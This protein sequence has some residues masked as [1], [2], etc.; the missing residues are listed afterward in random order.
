MKKGKVVFKRLAGLAILVL[1]FPACTLGDFSTPGIALGTVMMIV[2]LAIFLT[3][4]D[5]GMNA[6]TDTIKRVSDAQN[7]SI[8]ELHRA[9]A[10]MDTPLG[11]GWIGTVQTIAGPCLIYGPGANGEFLYIRKNKK[12][13]LFYL[14]LDEFD[15]MISGPEEKIA[16]IERRS[17]EENELDPKENVMD[18]AS[19]QALLGEITAAVETYV[20]TGAVEYIHTSEGSGSLYR[21]N[22]DFK[23]LGQRFAFTDM[24]GNVI[25]DIEGTFPL[26]AFT[27]CDHTTGEEVFKVTKRLI[28]V[29]PHYDFVWN[30][31]EY[32]SFEKELT[33][34]HDT[35]TM[36]T[37]E[38]KLEMR[39]TEATLGDNYIVRLNDRTI[40]TIAE[41][42]NFTIENIVFDNYIVHVQNERYRPLLAA[43]AVMAARELKRDEDAGSR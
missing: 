4:S 42:M 17:K 11:R 32:G 7:V 9:F 23:L 37:D 43:L 15:G 12:G 5:A 14:G 26:I 20:K 27:I 18:S 25:Y 16:E 40:G 8:E 34:T 2:G 41:K 21:F 19:T 10:E 36:Q 38:G 1:G 29:L 28:H 39:S 24:D 35:F 30:G 33:L 22:E 3:A 13:D 31:S 6:L